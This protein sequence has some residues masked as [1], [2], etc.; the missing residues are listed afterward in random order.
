MLYSSFLASNTP[1][2]VMF[3]KTLHGI[4]GAIR[5]TRNTP[6]TYNCLGSDDWSCDLS[7]ETLGVC[8]SKRHFLPVVP[9]RASQPMAISPERSTTCAGKVTNPRLGCRSGC[10]IT[11][12]TSTLSSALTV[13]LPAFPVPEVSADTLAP[14]SMLKRPVWNKL[15]PRVAPPVMT[16]IPFYHQG[17]Q[18][19]LHEATRITACCA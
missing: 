2:I 11:S 12:T 10:D 6:Y 13:K 19:V 4:D 14:S 16:S 3:D 15:A 9:L 1:D 8:R 17:E 5:C 7:W 18:A